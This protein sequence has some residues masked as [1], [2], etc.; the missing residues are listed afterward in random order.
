MK[1]L[2]TV[3]KQI[4]SI[5]LK[6]GWKKDLD[7]ANVAALAEEMTAGANLPPITVTANGEL[8][9][10]R[11]R[12][13]AAMELKL[14]S[15]RADVVSYEDDREA[16]ADAIAENLR[17]RSFDV[18]TERKMLARLVELR[19]EEEDGGKEAG[20]QRAAK[21]GSAWSPKLGDVVVLKW[22]PQGTTKE[23]R[24]AGWIGPLLERFKAH[25]QRVDGKGVPVPGAYGLEART[26]DGMDLVGPAKESGSVPESRPAKKATKPVSPQREAAREVA[27]ETG[28]SE[29]TVMRAVTEKQK[30]DS[31]E[32]AKPLPPAPSVLD[33]FDV[34]PVAEV[35]GKARSLQMLIDEGNGPLRKIAGALN[36]LASEGHPGATEL[37]KAFDDFSHAFRRARPQSACPWCKGER[38][39]CGPCA[40]TGIAT[41][42]QMTAKIPAVFMARGKDARVSDGRGGNRPVKPA[43]ADGLAL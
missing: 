4:A 32:P 37:Q 5:H 24:F 17:R 8:V 3:T 42:A 40:N 25:V 30:A 19:Q 7:E 6:S 27:K 10:G 43:K 26:F 35:E 2:K 1:L 38:K 9:K 16:E 21:A 22:D 18:V 15:I 11:H 23:A 34:P 41:E 20:A 31:P 12:L 14:K 29:R 36:A 33:W 13:A 28:R 39:E